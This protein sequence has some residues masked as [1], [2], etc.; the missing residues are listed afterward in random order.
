MSQIVI[1][2]SLSMSRLPRTDCSASSECG[3]IFNINLF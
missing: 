1:K 2:Q 3:G